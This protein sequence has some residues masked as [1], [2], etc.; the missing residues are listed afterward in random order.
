L[1][2]IAKELAPKHITVNAVSPGAIET[3][4]VRASEEYMSEHLKDINNIPMRR[5]GKPEEV[6]YLV[7][8]LCSNRADYIS[9]Q[10]IG[11]NGVA[12]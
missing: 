4:M 2:F 10:V 9:G 5:L 8:F 6:A 12:L 7:R 3:D 11:I 1:F